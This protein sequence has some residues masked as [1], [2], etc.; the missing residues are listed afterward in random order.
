MTEIHTDFDEGRY[1]ALCCL[2]C[3]HDRAV[4][5]IAMPARLYIAALDCCECGT[6]LVSFDAFTREAS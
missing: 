6:E 2:E 4:Y 3:Q 5:G 1:A